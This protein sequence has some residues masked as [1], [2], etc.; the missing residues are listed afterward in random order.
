VWA[1]LGAEA[2]RQRRGL[3]LIASENFASRAV[4]Q[5]LGS[6]MTNKY[7]EGRVGARYYGGAAHVDRLE[8][9]CEARALALFGL[10]T[11][12]WGVNVQPLS[13]S[14]ANLAVYLGLLAPG[15]RLMGLD[16]PA[17][18]HL[19]HGYAT[20]TRKVS[21][22]SVFYDCQPYG[23]DPTTGLV[24]YAA[25]AAS[26]AAFKPKLL[27]CG[28]SAYTREWDYGRLRAIADG[29]G[30]LL[31]ADMAHVAGLV[32]GGVA[33]SPFEHADVVTSTTHKSLRGPRAGLIFYRLA[34]KRAV[35]A[36]VFPAL[37]GGPHNN[38]IA[39]VAV[40]LREAAT[41]EFKVHAQQVV[42]NA[43]SLAAAL[44]RRGL[45]VATGGTDNHLVGPLHTCH[46]C[47]TREVL[48]SVC[49][50]GP[51][52]LRLARSLPGPSL[53]PRL[54]PRASLDPPLPVPTSG[55]VGRA[56]AGPDGR[57]SPVTAR[58]CGCDREQEQPRRGRCSGPIGRAAGWR[59]ARRG[60]SHRARPHRAALRRRRGP[61]SPCGQHCLRLP[62]RVLAGR[63]QG[64]HGQRRG[65]RQWQLWQRGQWRS[66][67]ARLSGLAG[68]R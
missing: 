42:A 49:G 9:L 40:A 8:A 23:L 26:A 12:E 45:C 30:S 61:P 33:A 46:T 60:S 24:D 34:H 65:E 21:A 57:P 1:I 38:A 55:A 25:L 68:R 67:V 64:H 51:S 58:R 19:S 56:S 54:S 5:A 27:V 15:D 16:L 2:R 44:I 62:Q 6:V 53:Y 41:P 22:A 31:M 52:P 36:A 18:G 29:C 14:P 11:R 3:E 17:G 50:V 28:A 66:H 39:A 47:R 35:D 4:L 7:S 37:Q 59:A 10:D 48:R 20:P 43:K 32:A 63:G 13:G